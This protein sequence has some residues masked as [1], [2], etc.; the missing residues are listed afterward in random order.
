MKKKPDVTVKKID[1]E[2]SI[3]RVFDYI[4][5]YL[6]NNKRLEVEK[7]IETCRHCFERYEFEKLLKKRLRTSKTDSPSGELRKRIQEVLESF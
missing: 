1:C 4:D 2:Q 6:K 7:H 3:K 5:G